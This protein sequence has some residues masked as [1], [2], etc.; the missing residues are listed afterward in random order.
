MLV[1][2]PAKI[3]WHPS[4]GNRGKTARCRRSR[5]AEARN[6]KLKSTTK[7][8]LV[9]WQRVGRPLIGS[10][11]PDSKDVKLRNLG[12]WVGPAPLEGVQQG[13]EGVK[14]GGLRQGA[15]GLTYPPPGPVV[16]VPC[17]DEDHGD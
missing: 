10:E 17:D 6:R 13:R 2:E 3:A 14:V 8:W 9:C 11:T 1:S 7:P 5:S 16:V 12:V 4:S 15:Q